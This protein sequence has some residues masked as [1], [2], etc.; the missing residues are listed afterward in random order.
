[1]RYFVKDKL[2][3]NHLTSAN[4]QLGIRKKVSVINDEER[5]SSS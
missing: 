3:C 2:A 1:M 5:V 4:P